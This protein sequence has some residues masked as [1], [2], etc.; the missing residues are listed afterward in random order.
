MNSLS[1]NYEVSLHK[2]CC[3]PLRVSQR[4]FSL[5]TSSLGCVNYGKAEFVKSRNSGN[6]SSQA[7]QE[8]YQRY[9]MELSRKIFG[10]FQPLMAFAQSSIL[11]VL[12]C[13]EGVSAYDLSNLFSFLNIQVMPLETA[14]DECSKKLLLLNHFRTFP[15]KDKR[16][17]RWSPF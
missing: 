17:T 14:T 4:S 13:S 9:K 15:G 7:Y 8:P 11:D 16:K 12:L 10:D 3:F 5:G 2:K 6:P 1:S